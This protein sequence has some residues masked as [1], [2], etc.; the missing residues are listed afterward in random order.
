M[1]ESPEGHDDLETIPQVIDVIKALDKET[2]PGVT[3][4]KQK[5]ELRRYN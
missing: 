1:E 4:A 2:E 3:S 5:V